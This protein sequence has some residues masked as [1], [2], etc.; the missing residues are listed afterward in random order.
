MTF[1]TS[2]CND[3]YKAKYQLASRVHQHAKT[4]LFQLTR[5]GTTLNFNN[6]GL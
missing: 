3:N 4:H 5:G 1:C 2:K 6:E